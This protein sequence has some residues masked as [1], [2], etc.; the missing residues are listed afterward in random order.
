MSKSD[1]YTKGKYVIIDDTENESK[2]S[3]TIQKALVV[4]QELIGRVLTNVER[5][6]VIRRIKRKIKNGEL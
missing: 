1:K 6:D 4:R 5:K 3:E 2:L